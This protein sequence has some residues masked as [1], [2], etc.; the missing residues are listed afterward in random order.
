M[1]SFWAGLWEWR[2]VKGGNN[3]DIN[4]NFDWVGYF[5]CGASCHLVYEFSFG[6][7]FVHLLKQDSMVLMNICRFY[8]G[9]ILIEFFFNLKD[10]IKRR[11]YSYS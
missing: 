4:I 11:K 3:M 2:L 6:V 7:N 1:F 10:M 8:F 5:I 9:Y